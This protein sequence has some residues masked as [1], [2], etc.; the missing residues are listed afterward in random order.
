MAPKASSAATAALTPAAISPP[1]RKGATATNIAEPAHGV[2]FWPEGAAPHRDVLLVSGASD[3]IRYRLPDAGVGHV[4]VYSAR[5]GARVR[6]MAV[7]V[8]AAARCC[9]RA[10]WLVFEP[11]DGVTARQLK[12]ATLT[13]PLFQ[14]PHCFCPL[15]TLPFCAPTTGSRASTSSTLAARR[16]RRSSVRSRGSSGCRC[17]RK[18]PFPPRCWFGAMPAGQFSAHRGMRAA[19]A[20]ALGA[21]ASATC[22][23]LSSHT[24]DSHRAFRAALTSHPSRDAPS[25][26]RSAHG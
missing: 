14:L 22:A 17:S 5:T 1:L 2:A 10:S 24:S 21:R 9:G 3:H 18:S 19:T 25:R 13:L 4:C 6:N 20:S 12:P 7:I 26:D 15:T 23:M 8:A 16:R 11:E